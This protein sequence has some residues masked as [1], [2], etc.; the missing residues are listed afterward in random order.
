VGASAPPAAAP[1]PPPVVTPPAPPAPPPAKLEPAEAPLAFEWSHLKIDSQPSGAEVV[2]PALGKVIGHTPFVFKIKPSH[3]ARQ[4][5]LRARGFLATVVEL[6]P[7]RELVTHTEKLERGSGHKPA[8]A[9]P[10]VVDP[11]KPAAAEPAADK[12]A[13]DKP[14]AAEPVDKPPPAPPAPPA[15]PVDK[16]PPAPSAPSAPSADDSIEP[17]LKAD[18][19]RTG[20]AAP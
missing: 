16:P 15:E 11:A 2:D 8:P 12:P 13:A 5:E 14:A 10:A 18:P 7:D 9:R 3:T 1:A 20:S 4:F 6:V 17:V 19:S